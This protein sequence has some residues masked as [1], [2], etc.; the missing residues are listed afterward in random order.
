MSSRNSIC[1]LSTD[2]N[3]CSWRK[4]IEYLFTRPRRSHVY[5]QSVHFSFTVKTFQ[6]KPDKVTGS[7]ESWHKY[8]QSSLYLHAPNHRVRLNLKRQCFIT[9]NDPSLLY[10]CRWAPVLQQDFTPEREREWENPWPQQ[11][12][13]CHT[14]KTTSTSKEAVP[15]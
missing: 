4:Q 11:A 15:L 9:C 7:Y 3:C 10:D 14:C 13:V 1:S 2:I 8:D 6:Q 5:H 12:I